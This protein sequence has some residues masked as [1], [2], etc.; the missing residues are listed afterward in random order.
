MEYLETALGIAYALICVGCVA[1][2]VYAVVMQ[3]IGDNKP[4]Q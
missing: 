1:A 4:K 2:L 3:V